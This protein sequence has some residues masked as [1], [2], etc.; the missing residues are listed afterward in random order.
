MPAKAT[1]W[2]DRRMS[3][4]AKALAPPGIRCRGGRQRVEVETLGLEIGFDAAGRRLRRQADPGEVAFD[5]R[6]VDRQL[7]VAE[8]DRVIGR[9][10]RGR[11]ATCGARHWRGSGGRRPGAMRSSV[12]ARRENRA[13]RPAERTLAFLGGHVAGEDEARLARKV[14][15]EVRHLPALARGGDDRLH[16]LQHLAAE[17]DPLRFD[18]DRCAL[19]RQRRD[20]GEAVMQARQDHSGGT[21]RSGV[22]PARRSNSSCVA[23]SMASIRVCGPEQ[24]RGAAGELE[25]P[26]VRPHLDRHAV[27]N[28]RGRGQL[29]ARRDAPWL[30]G[31]RLV[32]TRVDRRPGEEGRAIEERPAVLSFSPPSRSRVTGRSAGTIEALSW[33]S[34]VRAGA[35]GRA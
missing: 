25:S 22:T 6:I 10:D 26:L 8:A 28:H 3:A 14:G 32:A 1:D 31:R 35:G 15:L 17:H 18:A 34:P 21:G 19:T 5:G 33:P 20:R 11:R 23:V 24:G 7:E 27:G 29:H 2:A 4:S 12:E 16:R 13:R 30:V 9:L